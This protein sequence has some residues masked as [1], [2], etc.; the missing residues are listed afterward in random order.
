VGA[1]VTV[2]GSGT[3]CA[4]ARLRGAVTAP[5]A[6]AAPAARINHDLRVFIERPWQTGA[7]APGAEQPKNE[8]P[9]RPRIRLWHI[10]LVNLILLALFIIAY[11][12]NP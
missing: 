8:P 3:G 5:A 10:V 2:T 11:R 6:T 9:R 7:G 1:K 4:P 12:M